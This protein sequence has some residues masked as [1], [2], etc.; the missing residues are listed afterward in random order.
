MMLATDQGGPW[1]ICVREASVYWTD[2]GNGNLVTAPTSGGTPVVLA[3]GQ[4]ASALAVDDRDVYWS[5]EG[6]GTIMRV[7]R[8]GG[9][10]SVLATNQLQPSELTVD[11]ANVYW[12]NSAVGGSVMKL[13]K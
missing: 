11:D 12:I 3:T 4:N 2:N 8:S 1:N 7:P 9:T 5:D 13:V 10:P 6:S